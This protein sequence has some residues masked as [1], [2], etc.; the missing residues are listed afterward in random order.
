M[1]IPYGEGGVHGLLVPIAMKRTVDGVAFICYNDDSSVEA[2]YDRQTVQ[3]AEHGRI[4]GH[5]HPKKHPKLQAGPGGGG[6]AEP[7]P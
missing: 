3:E 2:A 5:L 4:A 6:K 7:D 1:I